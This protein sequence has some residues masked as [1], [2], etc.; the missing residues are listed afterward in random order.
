MEQVRSFVAIELPDDIKNE[1]SGLRERL[2]SGNYSAV[3]W[4]DPQSIHLTLK[5]LGGVAA[6]RIDVI[7]TALI[8]AA[9][10]ISPFH[11]VVGR[12]GVFPNPNRARVAWVGL[13]GDTD[14]LKQLQQRIEASLEKIGFARES[15][16]FTPHL[17][18][19]RVRDNASPQ[20][21]QRFGSVIAGTE[22]ETQHDIDVELIHL[23]R[24]QLTR[25]GAV[26]S[27]LGSIKLNQEQEEL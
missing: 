27:R 13:S 20:E 19:A 18:I 10:E 7:M 15:R 6:S 25:Q 14:K 8:E 21:R 5:F 12:P 24:S 23:M 11:L 2:M 26:Y 16:P 4:V 22:F 17:T 3:R 9:S 1:L